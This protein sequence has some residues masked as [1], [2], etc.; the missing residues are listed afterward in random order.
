MKG[1]ITCERYYDENGEPAPCAKGYA[2]VL[3][4]YDS[5]NRVVCEKFF[6]TDGNPIELA[7]GAACYRYTYNEAG[8]KSAPIK[9]DLEDHEI[10]EETPEPT[11]DPDDAVG[12]LFPL[13]RLNA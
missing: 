9:Y 4:E 8:E 3:R 13:Y 5:S 10:P 2:I 12:S 1:N 6:G 11:T 7:D